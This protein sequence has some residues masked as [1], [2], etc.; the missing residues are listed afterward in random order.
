MVLS[1][2]QRGQLE[3]R[4]RGQVDDLGFTKEYYVALQG[5]EVTSPQTHHCTIILETTSQTIAG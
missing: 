2:A 1:T 3:F 4:S 5:L